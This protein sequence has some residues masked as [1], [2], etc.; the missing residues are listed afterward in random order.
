MTENYGEMF[1]Y[2]VSDQIALIGLNR[3]RKRNAINDT[4]LE[5]LEQVVR[6][7]Q[8]EAKVAVIH[9][10]GDHF[11]AGLDLAEHATKT[12]MESVH[13]SRSWHA[14]FDQIQRGAIPFL[15][16]L[17]GA[18][19]GG[20]LELAASTH[21]RVADE[22][23][24]FALPEGQRGIFVG[25]G[26]SVRIARLMTAARMTDLMLTGRVLTVA[27]A[28]RFNLINYVVPKGTAFEKARALAEQ[29]ATNAPLS[30]FA[31]TNALPRI[32][33][34]AQEDGLFVESLMAAFTQTSPEA[35]KRLNEFTEKKAT[36]IMPGS[37]G[38]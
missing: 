27:E 12:P 15:S 1:T 31:I 20:G 6:R 14:V 16:A 28:E 26:G 25:G 30:N 22:S 10:H 32:Q 17:H 4:F 18:V 38:I 2:V 34:M 9:A 35:S 29:V 3:P 13:G 8:S 23:S 5:A 21:I 36:R 19:I 7:A 24:F 11:C 33:D 37:G